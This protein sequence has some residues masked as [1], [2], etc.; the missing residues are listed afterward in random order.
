MTNLRQVV[1]RTLNADSS[2]SSSGVWT[3]GNGVTTDPAGNDTVHTFAPMPGNYCPLYETTTQYYNGSHTSGTLLKT[4]KTGYSFAM[5]DGG[6]GIGFP[7]TTNVLWPNNQQN[8]ISTTYD[9]GATF[10]NP[11]FVAAT[12]AL[13]GPLLTTPNASYGLPL[14]VKEYDYSTSPPPVNLLR[15]TTTTYEALSNS[16]YL[17]NNL[18][19][20]P[21]S[22]AVTGSG[23]GSTTTYAYDQ[24]TPV[25]SGITTMHSSTP[26]AGTYRGNPTTVSRYLNT[27]GTYLSA[28]STVFDTGMPSVLTDPNGNLTTFGY[29]ST[30]AGA[31]MT[32]VTN[33]LNQ[34]TTLAYDFNTG[35]Q[36]STTDPNNQTATN[37][38][39]EMERLK[40]E[41]SPDGGQGSYTY[42]DTTPS[43]SVNISTTANSSGVPVTGIEILDGLGRLERKELTSDPSG[44]DFTDYTYDSL[45]RLY[46]V[47]NPYRGTP[48]NLLTTYN[49][50]AL[51]RNTTT[52]EADGSIQ[53]SQYCGSATLAVDEAGIWKRII[54]DG[55]GRISEVDEPTSSSATKN[56]CAGQG[57]PVYATTYAHDVNGN[58]T[59]VVQAG[60]RQR[61]L[62]YD[63]LSRLTSS[64][65]PESNT[66]AVSPFT[67]V[68]TT[69][70][71][72]KDGNVLSKTGPAPNQQGTTT[73]TI[74]Y[75]YDKLNR[76]TQ[77]AYTS[78]S[79]PMSAPAVANT[80]DS[81]SCLGSPYTC[82]NIGHRTGMTDAA[83]SES[84]AYTFNKTVSPKGPNVTDQRTTNSLTKTSIYQYN[85]D[86]SVAT[87]QYPSAKI[88]TYSFNGAGQPT[89]AA[90]NAS[91]I[92]YVEDGFYTPN[93]A[94]E[95]QSL[96]G[97]VNHTI[98]YN[99]RMQPCWS[100]AGTGTSL[101]LTYTCTSTASTGTILDMKYNYNLGTD[102][103]DVV[104]VTNDRDSTRSQ[105]YSYDQVN[106]VST[107]SASTYAT[108][109]ANCWGEQ[110]GFD[111]TGN[112]GN[113]LSISP[114]SSAYTGCTQESLSVAVSAYNR[115]SSLIYD[116]AGNVTTIPGTGGGSYVFN[117]EN[118]ITSTASINYTY[119]G[120]NERVAKSSGKLYWR[121]VDGTVLDETDL[122]GSTTNGSFNE[123]VYFNGEIIARRD[124]SNDAFYYVSDQI[125]SAR[126]I[127][128]VPGG[129]RTATLCFDTDYYPFGTQR[130]PIVSSCATNYRFAGSELDNPESSL[131]NS[132]ARFYAT[133]EGRFTSPDPSGL[134]MANPTDPQQL[135]LYSYVRNNPLIFADP[136]GLDCIYL[137]N[138]GSTAD[139]INAAEGPTGT[140]G[141][142]S[143]IDHN[144]SSAECTGLDANGNP[145]GGY[146]VEGHVGSLNDVTTFSNTDNI[147]VTS[148]VGG[149][150]NISL[151]S[152]TLGTQG[153]FNSSNYPSTFAKGQ[154]WDP[155]RQ[156]QLTGSPLLAIIP[157]QLSPG[158]DGL[159]N[160]MKQATRPPKAP[161][162]PS[163]PA[164]GQWRPPELPTKKPWSKM[165]KSEKLFEFFRALLANADES[166]HISVIFKVTSG[167]QDHSITNPRDPGCA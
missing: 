20:L 155:N 127:A 9:L 18:L 98:L 28:T 60:S 108:S 73:Q 90:D 149:V 5:T 124:S 45:G 26:P 39:D 74:S 19:T 31:L 119:D 157:G 138:D 112:W 148:Y 161:S 43:P 7:T 100:W 15:T 152:Q 10:Q 75:C 120:D 137:A 23:P 118:L 132:N 50:D 81:S 87:M 6:L 160:A 121:G 142:G 44:T 166:T 72:D 85:Y 143:S 159:R 51:S 27:T 67:A 36:T 29:S 64:T 38:Y 65:N 33:A 162:G 125:G 147:V 130:A 139:H 115:V 66:E 105:N 99:T 158:A 55:L 111:T 101:P 69:Y 34:T 123:Y 88:I 107:A 109:P 59:G 116:T 106:R 145:N 96:G 21:A 63:S 102:D 71:Y 30:Y 37:T 16:N 104:S 3:Y 84:W 76:M 46:T 25:S 140:T 78:Q 79:C 86:G 80:Y 151:A 146:W 136:T 40:L 62:V 144:S 95:S 14:T 134:S 131:Y 52:T 32:S 167:C 22:I 56:A 68:A 92:A 1:T 83:G 165:T 53:Q 122:T 163:D 117:A 154:F 12:S 47:S 113:L 17:I 82:V 77:K 156:D 54:T 103:G 41:M 129:T 110:F 141:G 58:L 93:G 2:D 35:L 8:Q 97:A 57:G 114:I 164:P 42:N 128:E 48:P 133:F 11:V 89:A 135:N 49:Y 94:L 24:T 126:T 4:V 70:T 13:A 61:A 150:Q 153:G 91:E